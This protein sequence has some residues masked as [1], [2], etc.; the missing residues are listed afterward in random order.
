VTIAR[1]QHHQRQIIPERK[2]KK[3]QIGNSKGQKEP[4]PP[5]HSLHVAFGLPPRISS[6]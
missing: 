4:E 1:N 5:A 6:T 2:E 3:G